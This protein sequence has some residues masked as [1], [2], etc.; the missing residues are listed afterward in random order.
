VTQ[1]KESKVILG[2]YVISIDGELFIEEDTFLWLMRGDLKGETESEIIAA[3]YQA[4]KT[5]YYTRKL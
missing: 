1:K 4:L 2:W 5:K 3:Q